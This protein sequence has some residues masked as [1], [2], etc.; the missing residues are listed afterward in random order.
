MSENEEVDVMNPKNMAILISAA[1]TAY[2]MENA[3]PFS[4]DNNVMGELFAINESQG[5]YV[6]VI[7]ARGNEAGDRT[8]FSVDWRGPNDEEIK[9]Y[10]ELY[11]DKNE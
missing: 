8:L 1:I 11:G 7:H 3:E 5:W 4:I 6:P 9:E 10:E 2:E